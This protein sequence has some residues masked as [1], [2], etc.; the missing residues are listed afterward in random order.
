MV[1]AAHATTLTANAPQPTTAPAMACW[2]GTMAY[3]AVL[4]ALLMVLPAS[5]LNAESA[6]FLLIIGWIG[7]WRYSWAT[8]HAGRAL[9]YAF[10]RFPR[11]RAAAD[12]LGPRGLPSHLFVLI[13]SYRIDAETN[14]AVYASLIDDV[15][16]CA[17][18]TIIVAA[19]SDEADERQLQ[20]LFCRLAPPP[21]VELVIMRQDGTG[22]RTAMSEGLRAISRRIPPADSLVLFM[23]GDVRLPRGTLRRTMPFFA[24]MPRLG[25]VTT[26]N[27]GITTGSNWVK[28]WYDMRFA[29]RHVLM[30]SLS[31]SWR[32]LV[33]TGRFSMFRA[34]IATDAGFIKAV[35]EDHIAHW[36]FG[37]LKFL[38]GDDKSTWYWVLKNRWDMLYLPDVQVHSFE[39]L[40]SP[41]L[42]KSSIQLMV[43]WFGNMMRN[44]GRAIALGPRVTGGFIW[45]SL[46]DQRL[47]MWTSLT[48]PV[49]TAFAAMVVSPV[50]IIVYLTWVMITRFLQAAIAGGVRRRFSPYMPFLLYYTQV[51]GSFVKIY[52]SF[53]LNRQRWTRQGIGGNKRLTLKQRLQ[54]GVSLYIHSLSFVTFLFLMALASGALFLPSVGAIDSVFAGQDGTVAATDD[55][56]WLQ[57]AIDAAPRGA[58]VRIPAGDYHLGGPI[59][60]AR[61]DITLQGAGSKQTRLVASFAGTDDALIT[62]AGEL[63]RDAA[64]GQ[65]A[66]LSVAITADQ[67]MVRLNRGFGLQRGDFVSLRAANDPSFLRELGAEVWQRRYPHLRQTLAQVSHAE[68]ASARLVDPVGLALPAGGEVCRLDVAENV[69]L[70]GFT[71]RYDLGVAS[72]AADYSNSRPDHRLDGV[73]VRGAADVR[74]SDIVVVNAGRHPI[75]LDTVVRLVAQDLAAHGAYNKG[76]GGNGYVRLA[77]TVRSQFDG[78]TLRGLR[79]LTIQWSS[80]G[81][82]IVDLDSDSDVNFHGGYTHENVVHA[83]RLSPRANHPWGAVTRTPA[84]AVWAPPDGPGN[85]VFVNGRAVTAPPRKREGN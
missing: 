83:T 6:Q 23:D 39:V 17:I 24:L 18:R 42:I 3:V 76:K 13:T 8:I 53:R 59:V 29:Q 14:A 30:C 5:V 10:I 67:T 36:R 32:V 71:L 16:E 15:S 25:G 12:R 74:L 63:P 70:R 46:V 38:T 80:H 40:P 60:I 7:T 79:H 54:N 28:E 19:V 84:D 66:E 20:A 27:R 41:S 73:A 2:L 62:I 64:A 33:L 85:K 43:R 56:R 34:D 68:G 49:A 57:A 72:D 69:S 1:P 58:V 81:N 77:R 9:I 61:D 47:S 65:C 51:V 75:H 22:K 35:E 48:G 52:V 82:R 26:D 11:L 45:W 4:V 50:L 21:G 37:H 44:N 55:A 31:L 78:L